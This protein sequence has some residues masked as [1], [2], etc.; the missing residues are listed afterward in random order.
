MRVCQPFRLL[1]L[2]C[3]LQGYHCLEREPRTSIRLGQSETFTGRLAP[4]TISQNLRQGIPSSRDIHQISAILRTAQGGHCCS[5]SAGAADLHTL[6]QYAHAILP[7]QCLQEPQTSLLSGTSCPPLSLG[8]C[9][10]G[11]RPV[12]SYILGKLSNTRKFAG[13]VGMSTQLLAGGSWSFCGQKLG[14]W[15]YSRLLR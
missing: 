8:F 4:R 13:K 1:L 7:A 6:G 2:M 15:R 11:S 14:H 10:S 12:V 3:P 9:C 5:L